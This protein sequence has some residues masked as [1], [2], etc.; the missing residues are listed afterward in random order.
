MAIVARVE[1]SLNLII[2][3]NTTVHIYMYLFVK[4]D[5]INY[6]F[7]SKME[8]LRMIDSK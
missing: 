6:S 7:V 5:L 8:V 1:S 2:G 4:F 3:L